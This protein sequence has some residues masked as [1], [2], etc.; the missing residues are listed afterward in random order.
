[1]GAPYSAPPLWPAF[2]GFGGLVIWGYLCGRVCSRIVGLLC[3][4]L[5]SVGL[6]VFFPGVLSEIRALVN[7]VWCSLLFSLL[8]YLAG[9]FHGRRKA[10]G[11]M[12]NTRETLPSGISS[13]LRF[14]LFILYAAA[15][16]VSVLYL[17]GHSFPSG[18]IFAAIFVGTVVVLYGFLREKVKL[19]AV[20][21]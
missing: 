10:G 5:P 19:G 4:P 20:N 8:G 6:G 15:F 14:A 2:L 16:F 3:L 7:F 1:M 21:K 13:V 17:W 9:F 12:L 18:Y 11:H